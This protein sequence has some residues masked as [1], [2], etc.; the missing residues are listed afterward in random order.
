MN[1][2]EKMASGVDEKVA[3]RKIAVNGGLLAVIVILAIVAALAFRSSAN[4]A[5]V[6][7]Q[8]S[9]ETPTLVM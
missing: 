5:N 3:L 9:Y 4:K 8:D 1:H 7:L 2:Q 6:K